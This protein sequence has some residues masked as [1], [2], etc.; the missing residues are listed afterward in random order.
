[1]SINRRN[2]LRGLGVTL[3]GAVL[4]ACDRFT[5]APATI[6]FLA[7]AENLTRGAQRL[8]GAHALAPEFSANDISAHFKA[9]GTLMPI[10]TEYQGHV[11]SQ[12][13]DGG[14]RRPV[15]HP[16]P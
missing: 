12:F 13:A 16:R 10:G 14:G 1:M 15:D 2:W 3:G 8:I 11:A 5:T 7:G 9:N 4:A 6:N